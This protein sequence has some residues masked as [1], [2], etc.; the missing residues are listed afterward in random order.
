MKTSFMFGTLQLCKVDNDYLEIAN[1]GAN[2]CA[3]V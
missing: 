3:D 2:L 1:V